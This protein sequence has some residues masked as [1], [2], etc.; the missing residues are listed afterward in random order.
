LTPSPP[1]RPI[2][3]R[4]AE[5]FDFLTQQAL[6]KLDPSPN[7][8]EPLR[9]WHFKLWCAGCSSG[10]EPYTQAMVLSEFAATRPGFS[11]AILATDI[12]TRVLDHAQQG[13]YDEAR[14]EPVALPLRKKY[15]LRSRD[16]DQPPRARGAG[17]AAKDQ[18]SPAE[19]HG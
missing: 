12:S 4:E 2:F 17:T 18:L 19:F 7:K 1:T 9:A 13:I 6:P 11:F 10:E 15:L 8:A 14:I 3:F 16:P 5:H